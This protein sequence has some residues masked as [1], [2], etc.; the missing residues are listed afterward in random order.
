MLEQGFTKCPVCN[1]NAKWEEYS[2]SWGTEEEFI[3]QNNH[4]IKTGRK[5]RIVAY[6]QCENCFKKQAIDD[7]FDGPWYNIED[8]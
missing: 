2:S 3:V 1:N 6:L 5:R 4:L 8:V 7:S